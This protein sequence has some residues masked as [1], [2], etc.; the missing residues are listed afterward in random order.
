MTKVVWEDS[1]LDKKVS[2]V[3]QRCGATSEASAMAANTVFRRLRDPEVVLGITRVRAS[4]Q[5]LVDAHSVR[6]TG[7]AQPKYYL[8]KG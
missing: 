7:P 5:R 4:L 2:E 8:R 6:K 3:L 1:D